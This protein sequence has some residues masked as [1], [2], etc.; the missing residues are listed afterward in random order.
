MNRSGRSELFFQIP[1]SLRRELEHL[2][3]HGVLAKPLVE[4][5][6]SIL[7]KVIVNSTSNGERPARKRHAAG[8]LTPT[9]EFVV[10]VNRRYL[11][12][13]LICCAEGTA[14]GAL[15]TLMTPHIVGGAVFS[16]MYG[17]G[18]VPHLCGMCDDT[19]VEYLCPGLQ[20]H[21]IALIGNDKQ[22]VPT[23]FEDGLKVRYCAKTFA[24]DAVKSGHPTIRGRIKMYLTAEEL[25]ALNP[26]ARR[27]QFA[28]STLAR[29]GKV[30]SRAVMNSSFNGVEDA[31]VDPEAAAVVTAEGEVYVGV[32]FRSNNPPFCRSAMNV[33]IGNGCTAGHS[34]YIGAL[35]FIAEPSAHRLEVPVRHGDLARLREHRFP[36]ADLLVASLSRNAPARQTWLTQLHPAF[37]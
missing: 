14:L 5:M 9:H 37:P 4:W 12:E 10:G 34:R 25:A 7:S 31:G 29:I 19:V 1:S 23:Y 35:N 26:S 8:F 33:A 2:E 6:W 30:L 32:N 20:K 16:D 28:P 27:G 15:I 21:P 11:D 18:E 13:S 22:Y 3:R 24:G 36:G 17:P